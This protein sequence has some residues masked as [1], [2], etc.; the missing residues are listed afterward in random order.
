MRVHYRIINDGIE[1]VRCFGTDPEIAV[2]EEIDGRPV[3][4]MAPYAF[5]A[6]YTRQADAVPAR[7]DDD[8]FIYETNEDRMFR[9]DEQ[10]L[11][12]DLVESVKLPDTMEEVGRYIFY[13]CRNLKVLW[14]SDRLINIGSGAFTGCRSLSQLHVRLLDGTRS[15]VPEILGDLWQRIDVVFYEGCGNEER[16]ENIS[17]ACISRTL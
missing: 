2:P 8:I 3:K 16:G 4:R 14:F 6:R 11:A 17:A 13:G 9:G 15:C 10:L 7:A 5:S 1:I 12:G